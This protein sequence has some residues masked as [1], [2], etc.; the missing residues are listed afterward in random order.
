[1]TKE[2]FLQW[3]H[4]SVTEHIFEGI[5]AARGAY[6]ERLTSGAT[7]DSLPE[8]AKTIGIIQAFDYLLH[9]DFEGG[10]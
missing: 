5:R 9:I 7:M 3:R 1:M 2:E 6:T 4:D 8:T 10:E